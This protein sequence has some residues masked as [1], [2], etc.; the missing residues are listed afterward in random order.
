MIQ[1]KNLA[2]GRWQELTLIQ[3][4]ANIGSEVSRTINWQNKNKKYY[5]NAFYRAL[6]LIDLTIADPKN[7]QKLKEIARMREVL[8][9][10]FWGENIYKSSD[11][12]WQKYFYAF[13][14]AARAK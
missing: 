4:M 2:R 11:K 1:H 14:W 7:K 6:E 12:F 9:D 3:Q 5:K 10:Y 8:V 13:T